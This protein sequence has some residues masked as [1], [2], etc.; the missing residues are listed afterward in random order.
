MKRFWPSFP[1]LQPERVPFPTHSTPPPVA[2][3]VE[4]RRTRQA[5]NFSKLSAGQFSQAW[6]LG[7]MLAELD[8]EVK[9]GRQPLPPEK[10]KTQDRR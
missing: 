5:A 1:G 8:A 4:K 10:P 9:A 7:L 6:T 3:R 2:S